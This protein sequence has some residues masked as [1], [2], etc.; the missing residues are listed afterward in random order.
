[1][2]LCSEV[3]EATDKED[4]RQDN[5]TEDTDK[6]LAALKALLVRL[7]CGQIFSLPDETR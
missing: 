1:V 2:T 3:E 6:T 4:N 5:S 7:N